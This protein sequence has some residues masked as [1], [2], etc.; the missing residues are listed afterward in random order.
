VADKWG[1]SPR[2]LLREMPSRREWALLQGLYRIKHREY[3]QAR[4]DVPVTTN[5]DGTIKHLGFGK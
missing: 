1:R 4:G 3:E 2:A 5:A